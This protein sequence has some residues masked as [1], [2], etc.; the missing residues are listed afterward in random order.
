MAGMAFKQQCPSCEHPVPIRDASFVGKK[1]ECPKCKYRFVVAAPKGG[2]ALDDTQPA[3]KPAAVKSGKPPAKPGALQID[4][5][6]EIA[7][8]KPAGRNK[9]MMGLGLGGVGLL[10]LALAS[11]FIVFKPSPTP[12]RPI[13]PIVKGG[14]PIDDPEDEDPAKKPEIKKKIETPVV[15]PKVDEVPTTPPGPW[16]TNLLPGD[17]EHV[18]HGFFKDV[19]D[20]FN[21]HR[22]TLVG[23]QRALADA[24]FKPRIGFAISDI[25]DFIRCD[26]FSPNPWTYT[27]IHLKTPV[28][29]KAVSAAFGLVAMPNI[30]GHE[31][32]KATKANPYFDRLS[33][34]AVGV[35]EWLRHVGRDDNR[36]MFIRFNDAQ[37]MIVAGEVPMK[38]LLK[39]DLQFPLQSGT[40]LVP[41]TPEPKTPDTTPKIE[42]K[43]LGPLSAE[44]LSSTPWSGTE[45]RPGGNFGAIR[46]TF[47]DAG[48]V[49]MTTPTGTTSGT[50]EVAE[51]QV[52]MAF[53]P[54]LKYTAKFV[55]NDLKGNAQFAAFAWQFTLRPAPPA[56][57]PIEKIDNSNAII[58]A[59]QRKNLRYLT[60]KPK[61]KDMLDRLITRDETSTEKP[62]FATA[63][64]LEP[65]RVPTDALPVDARG[66]FA[67]RGKQVW[68]MTAFLEERKPRLAL[69]GSSLLQRDERIF[70]YRNEF[71]TALEKDARD[72]L[73]VAEQTVGPEF[74]RSVNR[75]LRHKVEYVRGDLPPDAAVDP[76][77]KEPPSR[78]TATRR[79]NVVDVRVDLTFDTAVHNRS[80]GLAS[81]LAFA[82][83]AE[84]EL[85]VDPNGR[86][87][88]GQAAVTLAE[89]GDSKRQIAP[90]SF[91]PGTFKRPGATGRGGDTPYSRLSWMT[92]LLPF[93]GHDALYQR[94]DFNNGWRDPS[95]WLA[96]R[97]IVPEFLDPNYPVASRHVSVPGI[98][99]N[100]ATTH[101]V[102]I[103]G[104]GL[105]AADDSRDNP[106]TFKTRGVFSY[107][108]SATLEEI[109]KARGAANTIMMMQ[110]PYD[111][112]TGVSPWMAGGGATLRGVPEKNSIAP[113]VSVTEKGKRGTYAIM[114]DGSVRFLAA[115]IPDD[116]LKALATINAPMPK[117]DFFADPPAKTGGG[118]KLPFSK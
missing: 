47:T 69:A 115:D 58:Q 83:R 23:D 87:R 54:T 61:L 28:D 11:Y 26:R 98:G 78:W 34:I 100:P 60:I 117:G 4:D 89:K 62:L 21:P 80:Q 113:F 64:E 43:N 3:P 114:A 7:A 118:F 33:Q 108:K 103:A 9:L 106:A 40:I 35:P 31:Y 70:Q 56:A 32:F 71:E 5:D 68:D 42:V 29:E 8:P 50:F 110:V 67:W 105:D 1:V 38:E 65:A 30:K 44:A 14:G 13:V 27:V 93:L 73:K 46:M 82:I 112:I 57:G 49:T 91:P 94:I 107:D 59:R 66:N 51:Q 95:N 25:D 102:G 111:S 92:S 41:E 96:A 63:T 75:Y 55:G 16:L 6:E 72:L 53:S 99:V 76:T 79:D 52:T 17:T 104:V 45:T 86:K 37:T 85:A 84:V 74:A 24:V 20:V 22:A 19:F 109:Q 97:T 12:K 18:F 10:V 116:V 48:K 101:I 88:L 2:P 81:L 36:A 39:N 90:G 77:G 15:T